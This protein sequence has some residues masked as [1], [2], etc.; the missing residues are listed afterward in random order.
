VEIYRLGQA[1][2]VLQSPT[3]L[4]GEDVLPGFTLNLSRIW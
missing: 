1:V 3:S 4:S 2:E